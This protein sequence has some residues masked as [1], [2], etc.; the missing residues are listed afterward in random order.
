MI[1]FLDL[2]KI[3][4]I[5]LLFCVNFLCMLIIKIIIFVLFMVIFVC[6]LICV[7]NGVL[8]ILIL[9]VLIILK[10]CVNYLFEE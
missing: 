1:G 7:W 2:Y 3:W 4:V 8:L 6:V 5:I 9:F 10:L